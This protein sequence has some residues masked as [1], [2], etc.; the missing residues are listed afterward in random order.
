ML[1]THIAIDQRAGLPLD[2][3]LVR[4]GRQVELDKMKHRGV[5]FVRLLHDL[6][7]TRIGTRLV[8]E[9]SIG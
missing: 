2:A 4:R 7:G 8:D 3:D 1:G 9:F 6:R 5:H